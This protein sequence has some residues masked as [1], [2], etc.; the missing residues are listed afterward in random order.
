MSI[1]YFEGLAGS[2]KTFQLTESLKL[3]LKSHPLQEDEAILGITYM[4][5]S[6]RRMHAR[7]AEIAELRGRY[8][9]CTVD[10]VARN[11]VCRWRSLARVLDPQLDLAAAPDFAAPV[12][13]V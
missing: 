12:P 6:R 9:A 5:G 11:L 7:L 8:V 2:G 1:E 13:K 3:F 4:H 10:S